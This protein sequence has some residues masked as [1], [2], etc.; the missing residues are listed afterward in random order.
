MS[1]F[2]ILPN[3]IWIK[4]FRYSP[5][6][7][8]LIVLASKS[9]NTI[10]E[11]IK[12]PVMLDMLRKHYSMVVWTGG[13]NQF[14]TRLFNT[15]LVFKDI[16]R[17]ES[18]AIESINKKGGNEII[19]QKSK[20][21][22]NRFI[23]NKLD[24]I[25]KK[26]CNSWYEHDE[27]TAKQMLLYYIK[28]KYI[29]P[30]N[31]INLLIKAIGYH[32]VDIVEMLFEYCTDDIIDD[33]NIEIIEELICR[34]NVDITKKNKQ[35]KILQLLFKRLYILDTG[36]NSKNIKLLLSRILEIN[37]III[38]KI[39]MPFIIENL[40][41]RPN[42]DQIYDL[43]FDCHRNLYITSELVKLCKELGFKLNTI[44]RKL[45]IIDEWGMV[46]S[47]RKI[48][49]PLDMRYLNKLIQ[50]FVD[51]GANI[52]QGSDEIFAWNV[53][54]GNMFVV[55]AL[56]LAG[57]DPHT[58]NSA[59]YNEFIIDKRNELINN[60][61]DVHKTG[62]DDLA[63]YV[64]NISKNLYSSEKIPQS[65][66]LDIILLNYNGMAKILNPA[67]IDLMLGEEDELNNYF[68]FA[69]FA[70]PD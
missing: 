12:I 60:Y 49:L 16:Y 11:N 50:I 57:V 41:A 38:L 17:N 54:N 19:T 51:S 69:F 10:F 44:F 33:H 39:I 8:K 2:N 35:I 42:K 4:I 1:N 31:N 48:G 30:K 6:S 29:N 45:F 21:K 15:H 18:V 9:F 58:R 56:I 68:K 47:R 26:K 43:I 61:K 27:T 64:N 63:L 34:Y 23:I 40:K 53:R 65:D 67:H 22:Y 66:T 3:E 5:E 28:Y 37:S 14:T 20:E 24:L 46:I 70:S 32:F 25:I 59:I 7:I 62:K 13:I 52:H 36:V 55:K